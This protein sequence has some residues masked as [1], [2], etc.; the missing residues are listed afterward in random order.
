M[1]NLTPVCQ[2]PT[3]ANGSGKLTS[4]PTR[5]SPPPRGAL[6]LYRT[7]PLLRVIGT[8]SINIGLLDCAPCAPPDYQQ[9]SEHYRHLR[10]FPGYRAVI[11][12]SAVSEFGT[13][14]KM[15]RWCA[16]N[17]SMTDG[18]SPSAHTLA[19]TSVPS[20]GGTLT[21]IEA[22]DEARNGRVAVARRA[23][24]DAFV[25]QI[26]CGCRCSCVLGGGNAE[27]DSISSLVPRPFGV[28]AYQID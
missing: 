6:N 25:A 11:W 8:Y 21:R 27:F 17:Y 1:S 10:P 5:P 15:P 19:V 23:Q 24:E 3:F 14:L 7:S 16:T 12:V 13:Y 22:T 26:K 20:I 9:Q 2:T 18:E 4:R 28:P